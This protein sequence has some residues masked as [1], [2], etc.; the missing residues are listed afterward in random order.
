MGFF[1]QTTAAGTSQDLPETDQASGVSNVSWR[2]RLCRDL[3]A[4]FFSGLKA[5]GYYPL[6]LDLITVLRRIMFVGVAVHT[7]R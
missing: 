4:V 7:G 6:L 3:S 1:G 2:S 5:K